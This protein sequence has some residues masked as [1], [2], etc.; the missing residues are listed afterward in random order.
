MNMPTANGGIAQQ[1]ADSNDAEKN[2]FSNDSRNEDQRRGNND[3]N[4][5]QNRELAI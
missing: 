4:R 3:S 1:T 2:M 5:N